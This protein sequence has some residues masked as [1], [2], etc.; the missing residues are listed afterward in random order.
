MYKRQVVVILNLTTALSFIK[1]LLLKFKN[2][3][4]INSTIN[5]G[6]QRFRRGCEVIGSKSGLSLRETKHIV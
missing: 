6:M 3:A 2:S 5:M 4:I 1:K